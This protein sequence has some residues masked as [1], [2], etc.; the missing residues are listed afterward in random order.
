MQ[1]TIVKWGNS[2]GVRLPKVLLERVNLSDSDAVEVTV[3][4]GTIIIKK[5]EKKR[6]HIPLAARLES[7]DGAPYELTSEDREWLDMRPAGEEV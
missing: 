3:E 6:A 4:S 1:T 2:Q 5:V 7:W